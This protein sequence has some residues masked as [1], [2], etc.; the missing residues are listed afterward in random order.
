MTDIA[1]L[2]A[3]VAVEGVPQAQA[4]LNSM[5]KTVDGNAKSMAAMGT[6]AKAALVTGVVGSATLAAKH[7][8]DMGSSF[9]SA[10]AGVRKTVDATEAEFAQLSLGIRNMAKE[11]PATREEIAGVAEAAGQLGIKKEYLLDFTST[12]VDLGNTTNLSSDQAATSLARLANITQMPQENFDRLGSTVVALGNNLATTEAEIV[13]MGL[14]LAGA[15]KTVGMTEAQ[16]L[17][18]AGALSSVGIEAE[19][20]GTAFSRVMLNIKSEVDSGG[21]KLKRFAEVAGMT[22]DDFVQAFQDDAAGAIVAF[23]EGLGRMQQEGGNV[24][25]TLDELELGEI[26]VRD[27]LLRASNAGTCSENR[28]NWARKPGRKITA[29]TKEAEERTRPRIQG[30][31]GRTNQRSQRGTVEELQPT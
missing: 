19:A 22:S 6:A 17:S 5:G 13:Q 10:F 24:T 16:I 9:E 23:I 21:E 20:G 7:V 4:Q 1:R 15:G 28:W 14:R 30:E 26:R 12:M 3:R 18:L 27:A 2:I 11:L 29:L 31:I 25:G 8:Y